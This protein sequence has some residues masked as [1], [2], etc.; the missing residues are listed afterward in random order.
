M[1]TPGRRGGAYVTACHGGPTKPARSLVAPVHGAE[2]D[3][4]KVRDGSATKR[5]LLRQA[6]TLPCSPPGPQASRLRRHSMDVIAPW[7]RTLPGDEEWLDALLA[8]L[9]PET[10]PAPMCWV[11]PDRRPVPV[12]GTP[13]GWLARCR[14]TYKLA[15]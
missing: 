6:K 12:R 5:W 2:P 4:V 13:P 9:V 7:P 11:W 8:Q 3:P 1:R 10:L 14:A 15:A